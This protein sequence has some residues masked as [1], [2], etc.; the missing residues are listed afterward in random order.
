MA[1]HVFITHSDLTRL[2]CHAWLLPC[3]VTF[4]VNPVWPLSSDVLQQIHGLQT[5]EAAPPPGWGS[6]GVRV[7]AM[8][9]SEEGSAPYLVNVGGGWRTEIPWYMEGVRQFLDVVGSQ[10]SDGFVPT[11][12]MKPLVGLPLVGTG[13]G[14]ASEEKGA[15][16]RGLIEVLHR[17]AI[18]R[19]IDVVLVVRDEPAFMAAQ[20][21][22]REYLRNQNGDS[23]SVPWPALSR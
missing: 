11:G 20:N 18:S 1:G 21:A 22:R 5:G 9:G 10:V 3:D 16:V 23:L 13:M 8:P 4:S 2:N 19:N 14:G 12:R 7:L 15:V 17:E 6:T